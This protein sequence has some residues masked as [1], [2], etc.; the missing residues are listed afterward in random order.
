MVINRM[1]PGPPIVVCQGDTIDILLYNSLHL[2]EATSI[3][4]HGLRQ[5]GTPY[6]DGVSMITQ[7]PIISHTFFQYEFTA[8]TSGKINFKSN[9]KVSLIKN[10]FL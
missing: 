4:W 7:C 1:L 8:D 3:H 9:F 10:K 6:M 2:F 5:R